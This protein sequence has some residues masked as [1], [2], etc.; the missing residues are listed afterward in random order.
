MGQLW[1]KLA[2][3]RTVM[4]QKETK[5]KRFKS[6]K[7]T[8]LILG[9][10]VISILLALDVAWLL[11]EIVPF[12]SSPHHANYG[13]QVVAHEPTEYQ[14]TTLISIK[15]LMPAVVLFILAPVWNDLYNKIKAMFKTRK[16]RS[17]RRIKRH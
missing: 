14:A 3:K 1:G 15:T 9:F 2:M 6:L 13:G 8:G 7:T 4:D 12:L 16:K 11:T 5:S 17:H 10:I